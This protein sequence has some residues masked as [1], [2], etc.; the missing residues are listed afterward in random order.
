MTEEEKQRASLDYWRLVR[1]A[2]DKLTHLP[3]ANLIL[4]WRKAVLATRD[5]KTLSIDTAHKASFDKHS[6][7]LALINDRMTVQDKIAAR[8]SQA[9]P[10]EV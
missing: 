3:S 4:C 6:Y 10:I 8:V 7:E 9:P 2:P 5:D 1:A